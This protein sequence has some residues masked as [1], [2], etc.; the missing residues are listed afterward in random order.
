MPALSRIDFDNAGV[1]SAAYVSAHGHHC[2]KFTCAYDFFS[3]K[4]GVPVLVRRL[5]VLGF[6]QEMRRS[7]QKKNRKEKK[8]VG[9]IFLAL[10]T[11]VSKEIRVCTILF[12]I[13]ATGCSSHFVSLTEANT[14]LPKYRSH[15]P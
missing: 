2:G 1:H 6:S 14:Y 12:C 3:I 15:V 10:L 5:H 7:Q 9:Q 11:S 4:N 13:N 8:K